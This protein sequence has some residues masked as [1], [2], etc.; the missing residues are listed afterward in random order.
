MLCNKIAIEDH[1]KELEV[2]AYI[3]KEV[4]KLKKNKNKSRVK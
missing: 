4:I 3:Y 1:Y 2:E